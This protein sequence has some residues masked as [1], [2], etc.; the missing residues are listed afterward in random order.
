[1]PKVPRD[2]GVCCSN[3]RI[4]TGL[5]FPQTIP[6]LALKRAACQKALPPAQFLHVNLSIPER[7]KHAPHKIGR[8]GGAQLFAW[9]PLKLSLL[10]CVSS[11]PAF[12]VLV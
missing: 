2:S 6:Q 4:H 10:P 11:R 1:M 12:T 7:K 9:T 3:E 5:D 8:D